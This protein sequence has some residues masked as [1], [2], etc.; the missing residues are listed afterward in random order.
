MLYSLYLKEKSH[1]TEDELK[2]QFERA[3]PDSTLSD[4]EWKELRDFLVKEVYAIEEPRT[5]RK[6][7]SVNDFDEEESDSEN[8]GKYSIKY[9]GLI[10]YK[11]WVIKY[12]PKYFAENN[13]VEPV[14]DVFLKKYK[15]VLK[16]IRKYKKDNEKDSNALNLFG[17]KKQS[18]DGLLSIIVRL[19]DDYFVNGCY[20]N[21]RIIIKTNGTGEIDWN[22]TVNCAYPYISDG[23][24]IY[25]DYYTRYREK[26]TDDYFNRLHRCILTQCSLYLDEHDLTDLLDLSTAILSEEELDSFGDESYILERIRNERSVQFNTKKLEML[27]LMQAYV[28][29]VNSIGDLD[30]MQLYGTYTYNTIWEDVCKKVFDDDLEKE[31]P[32][33]QKNKVEYYYKWLTLKEYP[34]HFD[35]A[36]YYKDIVEKPNWIDKVGMEY[37]P[38]STLRLDCIKFNIAKSS[39]DIYDAKYYVPN[40]T[41]NNK[42]KDSPRVSD[43]TKQYL[44]QLAFKS[45][46]DAL[47]IKNISNSFLLPYD[48]DNS[49]IWGTVGMSMFD[50]FGLKKINVVYLCAEKMYDSY[51]EDKKNGIDIMNNH[52][53]AIAD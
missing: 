31:I 30:Q 6:T 18:K 44:Y 24:P 1:F 50:S 23:R 3:Y 40:I 37:E 15:Q 33:E 21:D 52:R 4:E 25:F 43:V 14:G 17:D 8:N 2:E 7:I 39:M 11:D 49:D 47:G 9:V 34:K 53:D 46:S 29:I 20:E 10:V 13:V 27:E 16:V 22:R 45:F 36:E 41:E 12:Y 42:I 35:K 19:L 32:A 48:E 26:N 51:L 5:K 28:E 38:D